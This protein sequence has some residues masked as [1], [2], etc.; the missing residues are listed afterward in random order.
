MD[1]PRSSLE[2]L[3][4]FFAGPVVLFIL[5]IYEGCNL[6]FVSN[7][8]GSVEAD[9]FYNLFPCSVENDKSVYHSRQFLRDQAEI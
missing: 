3:K 7:I 5:G 4:V 2:E 8:R 1:S 6:V 9:E